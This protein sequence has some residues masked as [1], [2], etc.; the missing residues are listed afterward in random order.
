MQPRQVKNLLYRHDK[1]S[2]PTKEGPLSFVFFESPFT[3]VSTVHMGYRYLDS[4]RETELD[5]RRREKIQNVT[6]DALLCL[7][8]RE[9]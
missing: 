4:L 9:R 2:E 8:Q 6:T 5:Q 1:I 3:S 7:S